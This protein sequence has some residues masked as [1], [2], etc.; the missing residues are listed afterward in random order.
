[1]VHV[2]ERTLPLA[3]TLLTARVYTAGSGEPVMYFHGAAGHAWTALH[4][5]LAE[6]FGLHAPMHPGWDNMAD[7]EQ[8]DSVADL[9]LYYIDILDALGIG[10]TGLVGHSVGGMVAAEV[11][12]MRPDRISRVALIAPWGLWRDDEPV[13]DIWSQSPG[14]LAALLWHEPDGEVARAHAPVMEPDALLR[15]YLAGAAAAHFTWPIPDRGLGRRLHRVTAPTVLIWGRED[16]VVPVSYAADFAER[17]PDSRTVV[18]DGAG[19][20]V[21]LERGAEVADAVIEHLRDGR[22]GVDPQVGQHG[23]TR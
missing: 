22:A 14:K 8:F 9:V 6:Q 11:A 16:K 20:M 18:L 17:L 19:H 2:R 15:A 13:A 23:A 10:T 4:D 5:R 7:L 12:A 21:H 3:G 1:V